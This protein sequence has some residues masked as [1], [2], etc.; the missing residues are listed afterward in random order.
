MKVTADTSVLV[1][2]FASWHEHHDIAFA[3]A[4]RLDGIVAHCLLETYSVLTRLPAPHRMAA[5]VVSRYLGVT[6]GSHPVFGLPPEDQRALVTTCAARGV[7]GGSVYD[8]VIA[9]TCARANVKLLT[10]DG[11]ARQTYAALAVEHELIA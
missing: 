10:L 4:G 11:R 1:A 5:A 9:A 6:F 7:S 3:A 8:A 2:C